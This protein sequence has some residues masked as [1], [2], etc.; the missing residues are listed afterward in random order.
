MIFASILMNPSIGLMTRYSWNGFC[1]LFE[2]GSFCEDVAC[3]EAETQFIGFCYARKIMTDIFLNLFDN[4]F[5][6]GFYQALA[7]AIDNFWEALDMFFGFTYEKIF[8]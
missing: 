1:Y 8:L 6:M 4:A 3:I 2:V 7:S 5:G